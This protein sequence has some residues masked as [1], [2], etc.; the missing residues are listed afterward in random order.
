MATYDTYQGPTP[1]YVE[2]VYWY[3]LLADA[4]GRTVTMLRNA[5]GECG[6]AL[7]FNKRELPAFAQWKNTAAASDGYVTGLEPATDYPNAKPFERERGRLVPM[8]P[9]GTYTAQL[10]LEAH[11][12]S[13]GVRGVEQEIAALQGQAARLV[14]PRPISAYS[15]GV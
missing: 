13:A 15:P 10:V 11:N 7:R 4:S 2:Q 12:T 14:H 9:G 8:A 6:L 1:G 3:D 5:T